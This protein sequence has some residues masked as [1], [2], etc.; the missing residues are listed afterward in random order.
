MVFFP[1]Q[2]LFPDHCLRNLV[3]SRRTF[4]ALDTFLSH[5][6]R[7]LAHCTLDL[8][9]HIRNGSPE[10][11]TLATTPPS[12]VDLI[13]RLRE[14]KLRHP[15]VLGSLCTVAQVGAAIHFFETDQ[16]S[17]C[18]LLSQCKEGRD[19]KV[20]GSCTGLFSAA[21]LAASSTVSQ[22]VD[23]G[24]EAVRLTFWVGIHSHQ[25]AQDM[26][27]AGWPPGL[28][29]PNG[30]SKTATTAVPNGHSDTAITTMPNDN[31][32][33]GVTDSWMLYVEGRA[34][35]DL[36]NDIKEYTDRVPGRLVHVSATIAT[37]QHTLNGPPLDLD[38]LSQRLG[39]TNTR[40]PVWGLYHLPVNSQAFLD[41]MVE[42]IIAK[43]RLADASVYEGQTTLSRVVLTHGTQTAS[44]PSPPRML[45]RL[46]QCV[47]AERL[48]W[49]STIERVTDGA[50]VTNV[51]S[52][53]PKSK[54][55]TL[56]LTEDA[57]PCDGRSSGETSTS[58]VDCHVGQERTTSPAETIVTSDVAIV[59][60]SGRFPEAN[61]VQE[62]WD[63]VLAPGKTTHIEVPADRFDLST[64][65]DP[66]GK[67]KNSTLAKH[68]CFLDS[69]TVQNFDAKLF[70][71][72]P[73]E[74][75]QM[76]PQQRL[77]LLCTFEALEEA[78]YVP[79]RT[80]STTKP[81]ISTF[82]GQ[83]GEDYREVCVAQD[84]DQ[85][86]ADLGSGRR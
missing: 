36:Q 79:G 80:V 40:V 5:C 3:A 81:R 17:P 51:I 84:I 30:N 46:V 20:T 74:A 42:S 27:V 69:S 53:G 71:V 48:D 58:R 6:E 73:R 18:Q 7:D 2:G 26:H 21:A 11:K 13:A 64:H 10:L 44:S 28:A 25:R 62:L 70:R 15:A 85:V 41:Q 12:L 68:G 77:S 52:F 60:M 49:P 72:S 32:K 82:I 19:T 38:A 8:P 37:E 23:R 14:G 29:Q 47:V 50:N 65:H 35:S 45:Q 9:S 54:L 76:D 57:Q 34:L 63:N 16:S 55:A 86:S 67:I 78:G 22:L 1:D 66:T 61:S 31:A 33:M 4:R 56:L 75:Q 43:S 59:G 83:A 39:T 24:R